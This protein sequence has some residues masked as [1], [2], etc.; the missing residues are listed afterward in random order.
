MALDEHLPYEHEAVVRPIPALN[1]TPH[2]GGGAFRALL[3]ARQP[4]LKPRR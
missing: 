2:L 3:L 4:P 1:R